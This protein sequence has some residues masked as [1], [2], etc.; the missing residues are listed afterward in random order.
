MAYL[1]RPPLSQRLANLGTAGLI[2]LGFVAVLI[3]GLSVTVVPRDDAPQLTA[4]NIIDPPPP[5]PDDPKPQPKQD[6][7]V[8]DLPKPPLDIP[9]DP[10]IDR[11]FDPPRPTG[12][13]GTV[14]TPNPPPTPLPSPRFSPS[15][16]RPSNDRLR[17]VTTEDYPARDLREG[18][19][20]TTQFRVIVGVNGRV[21]ECAVT[22]TSG[23]VSLDKAACTYLARRARFT[24]AIDETGAKVAGTYSGSV[25][26]RIP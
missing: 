8:I 15:A 21:T 10:P 14:L 4:H 5:P 16:A 2:E 17:W 22:R 26:W 24:A 7:A 18:N 20:G 19:Q 3:A 9:R 13:E 23:F 25:V 6:E 12:D 11:P 1:D